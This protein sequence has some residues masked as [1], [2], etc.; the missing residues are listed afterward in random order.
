VA[1][2]TDPRDAE[3][4]LEV[5]VHVPGN[6]PHPISVLHPEGRK[7]IRELFAASLQ[8]AVGLTMEASF[9]GA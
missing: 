5:P 9:D 3:V 2:G 7:G 1:D 8:L 4:E 6:G